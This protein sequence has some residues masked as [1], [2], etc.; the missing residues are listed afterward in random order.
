MQ[1]YNSL[2]ALQATP[3]VKSNFNNN[4][5]TAPQAA[6]FPV[7]TSITGADSC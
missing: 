6:G 2:P 4:Y 5:T 7:R 1:T 3:V